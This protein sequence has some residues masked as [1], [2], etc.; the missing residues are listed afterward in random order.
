MRPVIF[1]T[2]V[3]SLISSTTL[4][5]TYYISSSSGVNLRSDKSTSSKVIIKLDYCENVKVLAE[6]E[7]WYKVDYNGQEGFIYSDLLKK[8]R[9]ITTVSKVRVGARCRDG[10]RSN[11]TGRGACSHHGGVSQ[12]L[13]QERKSYRIVKE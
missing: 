4:G 2:I 12:W 3:S 8:G 13:T 9:C 5:Q 11:A 1:F 10:S 7:N 6:I